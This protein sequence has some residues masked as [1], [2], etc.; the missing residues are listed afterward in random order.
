MRC[1]ARTCCAVLALASV[2]IQA[3]HG[4]SRLTQ[5]KLSIHAGGLSSTTQSILSGGRPRVVKLLDTFGAAVQ[6]VQSLDPGVVVLGRIYLANQPGPPQDP[7]QAATWWW[8]QT[9]Q[10]ILS[11]PGVAYWE[12]LNEPDV[13]STQAMQWLASF[14]VARVQILAAHGLAAAVGSFATGTPDVTNPSLVS[15]FVPALEA[16]VAHGGIL[17]LHEYASPTMQNC[18]DNSTGSGWF[19]G[20]Y[21]KLYALFP[22]NVSSIPLII[23][24]TGIDAVSCGGPTFAGYLNA[25]SWWQSNGYG[26]DCAHAYVSQ[27]AW[28]DSILREDD[29]VLGATIFQI[30][31]PGWNAY[32]LGPSAGEFTQYLQSQQ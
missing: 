30:D 32:D 24:E 7:V 19:T 1:S 15:L 5:S 8:G 16:A 10:T 18:F 31:C 26:S 9:N 20:R 14:E 13:G 29:F 27:L 12:G 23:S 2:A 11:S 22:A 25:C 17:T 3:A 28:Y 21:R 6:Q 4:Q